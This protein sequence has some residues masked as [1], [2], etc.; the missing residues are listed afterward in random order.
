[1]RLALQASSHLEAG[2]RF[3]ENRP[4]PR[5]NRQEDFK[6]KVEVTNFQ[7]QVLEA[8]KEKPILVDFWAPWCGPCRQLGPILE[9][10]AEEPDAGFVLA[11]VN[12][13][14]DQA[15]AVRYNIRSIPAVK[16]FQ[17]GEV[18]DEF[19]GALPESQVRRWL[20]NALPNEAKQRV[21]EAQ[22]LIDA[23]D[24]NAAQ[25]LLE[26]VLNES[27]ANAEASAKLARLVV[28]RQPER[29]IELA[30]VAARQDAT[31][32]PESQAIHE[33]ASLQDE[34]LESLPED[35]ARQAYVEALSALGEA[36]VDRALERFVHS[37]RLNKHFHNDAARRAA[38]ALFTLLG[39]QN[40]LTKKH[41][42]AL[43]SALF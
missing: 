19:L 11:K 30:R 33:V 25:A 21:Q 36:D 2:R 14:E 3:A 20:Q 31:F 16:L 34:N 5:N 9:K 12:T 41:R 24:E 29:A 23:G 32:V 26:Q 6:V 22:A 43:E 10:M 37:V 1:L 40:E 7:E 13:D 18:K 35:P 4:E 8:S 39:P 27:P 17:D 42:R 15:T 28:F 38:V